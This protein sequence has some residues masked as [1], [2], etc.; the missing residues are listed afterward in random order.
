MHLFILHESSGTP[1]KKTPW[2][3]I[4]TYLS[5]AVCGYYPLNHSEILYDKF[6]DGFIWSAATAAYQVEGAWNEDG[7]M[8]QYMC[9]CSFIIMHC[10]HKK[11]NLRKMQV[12]TVMTINKIYHMF[13]AIKDIRLKSPHLTYRYIP[14][15]YV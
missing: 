8:L 4:M 5:Y 15:R 14:H 1:K 10:C 11:N 7:M 9:K 13:C 2:I 12:S 3:W 6:P